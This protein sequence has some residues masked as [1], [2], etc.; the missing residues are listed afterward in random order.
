M[1]Q[2]G[3]AACDH[4]W[5]AMKLRDHPVRGISLW[6]KALVLGAV[7]SLPISVVTRYSSTQRNEGLATKKAVSSQSLETKRQH[8]LND[9]F[10]WSA[11]AATSVLFDPAGTPAGLLSSIPLVARLYPEE[12]LHTRPPPSY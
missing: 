11:S 6:R 8:L 4:S 5:A 2:T 3:S 10:Y 9:G 1:K 7:L 12:Y